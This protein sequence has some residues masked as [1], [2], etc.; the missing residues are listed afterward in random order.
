MA[1]Y[2]AP[3]VPGWDTHGLPIEQQVIKT[4]KVNRHE[5]DVLEFRHL[6]KEYALKYV[7]I[8]KKEFQRLGVLGDWDHPYL[9]LAPQYEAVQ[10]GIFGEMAKKGYIYKGL[11]PVYWCIDCET[12]LAEAEVEYQEDESDSIYVLFPV[13]DSKGLFAVDEDTY[14]LIW[15]T[16][17]GH[18]P[19]NMAISLHPNFRYVLAQLGGKKVIVAEELLSNVADLKGEKQPRIL[20]SWKGSELE[21]IRCSHPFYERDSL[22][23]L[24]EH[25]TLEQGT[26]AVHTAPAHGTEDFEV[27]QKYGIPVLSLVDGQGRFISEAGIFAGM[28]VWESNDQVI[29]Q[30]EKQGLLFEKGKITHQYPPLLAVQGPTDVQSYRAVVCLY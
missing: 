6:C 28:L 3:Y 29:S 18:I 15:T 1:G 19:G 9:T 12:A 25:V 4:R 10:I 20:G 7:E 30:L 14:V 26:G 5:M 11:K 2:D 24:G 16:T 17:P 13:K 8:Q 21:G 27:C 22:V 23:I